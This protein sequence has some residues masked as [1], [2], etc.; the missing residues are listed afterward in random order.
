MD[1][2]ASKHEVLRCNDCNRDGEEEDSTGFTNNG[3]GVHSQANSETDY[4]AF[5]GYASKDEF[6][7]RSN[8]FP[9]VEDRIHFYMSDWYTP[10]CMKNT[11]ALFTLQCW[12]MIAR[13]DLIF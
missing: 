9:S 12:R 6:L 4:S 13:T 7:S 2:F 8:R 3:V 5:H 10:P 11:M 1:R